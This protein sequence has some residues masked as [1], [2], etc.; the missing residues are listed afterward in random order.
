[1]GSAPLPAIAPSSTELSTVPA[2]SATLPRSVSTCRRESSRTARRTRS[3]LKRPSPIALFSAM[4]NIRWVE[5]MTVVRSGVIIPFWA[6]RP[7]SRSSD[8][9]RRST[10]PGVGRS[11][12]T[13]PPEPGTDPAGTP[14][15]GASPPV[16]PLRLRRPVAVAP[17]PR[18]D[19]EVVRGGAGALRDSGHRGRLHGPPV[20]RGRVHEPVR[21]HAAS[22]SAKGRDE[23]RP[24]PLGRLVRRRPAVAGFRRVVRGKAGSGAGDVPG[25][26]YARPRRLGRSGLRRGDGTSGGVAARARARVRVRVR[27]GIGVR[28][29]HDGSGFGSGF[30]VRRGRARRSPC[31]ERRKGAGPRPRGC[32]R[33]RPGR[34]TGRAPRRARPRRRGRIPRSRC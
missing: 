18:T 15:G 34:T 27:I 16:A 19:L 13:R 21:E 1:M 20:L 14:S 4:A 8:A 9:T 26:R 17:A 2:R 32:S 5:A 6:A 33:P 28:T 22:L 25:V 29:G 31:F 7:A 3:S 23:D 12:M 10:L 24:G 11:A 30:G